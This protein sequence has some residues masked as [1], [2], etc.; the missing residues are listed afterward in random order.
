MKRKSA[1]WL[2]A[3]LLAGLVLTTACVSASVSSI[4]DDIGGDDSDLPAFKLNENKNTF[5]ESSSG[6]AKSGTSSIIS[7]AGNPVGVSYRNFASSRPNE[8]WHTLNAGGYFMNTDRITGLSA[9]TFSSANACSGL[10]VTWSPDN[11]NGRNAQ[12]AIYI[13]EVGKTYT[14]DFMSSSPN[15]IKFENT[16]EEAVDI[17]YINI[18]FSCTNSY[19]TLSV[20]SENDSYGTVSGSGV[21]MALSTVTITASPNTGYS[22]AGWYEG[23]TL[24]STEQTY[25]FSMP[26]RDLSYVARWVSHYHELNVSTLYL[27]SD[28]AT[29]YGTATGGGTKISGSYCSVLATPSE[30]YT[31]LGWYEGETLISK[32]DLYYFYMPDRDANY[33]AHFSKTYKVTFIKNFAGAYAFG[34]G[35]Y[36]YSEEVTIGSTYLKGVSCGYFM[37]EIRSHADG[38]I[39]NENYT[40]TMPERDM[41]FRINF[42]AIEKGAIITM[43]SWPQSILRDSELEYELNKMTEFNERGFLEY[44]GKEYARVVAPD[45]KSTW[46]E[47][48]YRRV[49]PL[50]EPGKTFYFKVEPLTWKY[51]GGTLIAERIIDTSIYYHSSGE[52]RYRS[53]GSVIFSSNYEYS[54]V[55]AYLNGLNGT[56]Y[57]V[58]DFSGK[59]IYDRAFTEEEKNIIF[60]THL[61]SEG[62]TIEDKLFLL[63]F[64]ECFS[65]ELGF[66]TDVDAQ[67]YTRIKLPTDY[68]VCRGIEYYDSSRRSSV[69]R[70][71]T[72]H[73]YH[74]GVASMYTNGAWDLTSESRFV[75]HYN[76][77][78]PAFKVS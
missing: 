11:V 17:S 58:D 26:F 9:L 77:I 41:T 65:E 44:D 18:D 23:E 6:E 15:F 28:G 1:V 47:A 31:F 42:E 27:G 14:C 49:A 52:F 37:K 78:V 33:V 8:G 12:Y 56:G 45:I 34:D 35:E 64:D 22:F 19:P 55:R 59:G 16:G 20:S 32:D 53:D 29:N 73:V 4:P 36:G 63:S 71:R 10:K 66:E 67:S 50:Y 70:T 7:E 46:D 48:Q 38:F 76:G 3:S 61:D 43:G 57:E 72:P 39:S 54:I 13:M 40:F 69:W 25:T 24:V 75:A 68:A 30:G 2:C 74:V 21:Y 5:F 51:Y 60:T 62:Y